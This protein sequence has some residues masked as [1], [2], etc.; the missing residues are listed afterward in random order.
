MG[1]NKGGFTAIAQPK[2]VDTFV[3]GNKAFAIVCS[4]VARTQP[5]VQLID[6]S[7]PSKLVAVG[8][9]KK[10][11]YQSGDDEFEY[12]D[13]AESVS[14]F[15]TT[16]KTYAILVAEGVVGKGVQLIDVSDPSKPTGVGS[17]WPGNSRFKGLNDR[18]LHTVKTF[19]V[20]KRTY[21]MV[22]GTSD[23]QL[24][25]VSNP[26]PPDAFSRARG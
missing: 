5:G 2:S 6:I 17:I 1:R 23:M 21:A 22:F 8:S 4:K 15:A 3:I 18:S 11:S 10:T 24:I 25:D 19:A 13:N 20:G 12:L 9:A 7:D 16:G 14:T 26:K